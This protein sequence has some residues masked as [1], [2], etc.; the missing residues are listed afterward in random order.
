M[1]DD[2]EKSTI[3]L[4]EIEAWNLTKKRL[5][6][7]CYTLIC[8]GFICEFWV[9]NN[10]LYTLVLIN[11]SIGKN[12]VKI[13]YFRKGLILLQTKYRIMELYFGRNAAA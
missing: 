4:V 8:N 2:N 11:K 1:E 5:P 6:Y 10:S 12:S 9:Q 13:Y 3:F 7:V